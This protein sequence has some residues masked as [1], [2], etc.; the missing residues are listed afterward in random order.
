ME[1]ESLSYRSKQI[2]GQ[3]LLGLPGDQ[4]LGDINGK[5]KIRKGIFMDLLEGLLPLSEIFFPMI[6]T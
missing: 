6:F 1:K 5:L 4:A 3:G 2:C